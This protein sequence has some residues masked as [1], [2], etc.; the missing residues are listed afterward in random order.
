MTDFQPNA[1]R[2][3]RAYTLASKFLT[4][5]VRAQC[6]KVHTLQKELEEASKAIYSKR[7]SGRRY[8]SVE[9]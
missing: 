8:N 4:E 7:T 9:G 3:E 6:E 1:T 2:L 5:E